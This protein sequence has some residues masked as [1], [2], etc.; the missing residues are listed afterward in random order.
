MTPL[1]SSMFKITYTQPDRPG[2]EPVTGKFLSV[3]E[4][5]D[6]GLRPCVHSWEHFNQH[7]QRTGGGSG[8]NASATLCDYSRMLS[9]G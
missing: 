8:V 4:F 9:T 2:L 5:L 1:E 6:A 7:G 3:E